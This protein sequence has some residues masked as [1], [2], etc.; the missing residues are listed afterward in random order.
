MGD[1]FYDC[2]NVFIGIALASK[3]WGIGFCVGKWHP[4]DNGCRRVSLLRI[5]YASL[6]CSLK[7]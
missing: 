1:F 4:G 6:D 3:G 7:Q 2:M 5:M